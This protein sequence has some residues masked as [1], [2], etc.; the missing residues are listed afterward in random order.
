MKQPL[1]WS[2]NRAECESQGLLWV[3]DW[4]C[5]PICQVCYSVLAQALRLSPLRLPPFL[6]SRHELLLVPPVPSVLVHTSQRS[7]VP[8]KIPVPFPPSGLSGSRHTSPLA[9]TSGDPSLPNTATSA[10]MLHFP[11]DWAL[12]VIGISTEL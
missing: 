4:G 6:L 11:R 10:V 12:S 5:Y 8:G 7:A 3:S 9:L 1:C 2:D